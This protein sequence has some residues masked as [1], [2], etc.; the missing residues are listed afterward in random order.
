MKPGRIIALAGLVTMLAGVS[1]LYAQEPGGWSITGSL[2]VA[3]PPGITATLLKNG[4]VL[5]VGGISAELYEPETGQWSPAGNP[6]TPRYDHIAVRLAN[7]NVLVAGGMRIPGDGITY[8]DRFLTGAEIYDPVTGE[9]RPAGNL[10]VHRTGHTAHLLADG[11]V[12]VIGGSTYEISGNFQRYLNHSSA[13]IYDPATNTWSSAGT[14]PS[15]HDGHASTLLANGDVLVVGGRGDRGPSPKAEIFDG[16]THIWRETGA[17]MTGRYDPRAT[18]LPDGKVLVAGGTGGLYG[19]DTAEVYDPAT[20]RW[21]ET[22]RMTARRLNHTATLLP[23]GKVLVAG[24]HADLEFEGSINVNLNEWDTAELYDPVTGRW[25]A[26]ARMHALHYAHTAT[27]LASGRVLVVG[28]YSN[29]YWSSAAEVYDTGLPFLTLNSASFC[30]GTPW[31]L[32]VSSLAPNSSIRLVGTSNGQSWEIRDWQKTDAHGNFTDAGAFA[33]DAEGTHNLYVEV[34]G[35]VSNSVPFRVTRC[36]IQLTLNSNEYCTGAPWNLKITSDFPNAWMNLSGTTN[37]G[38]WE[39]VNWRRTG[40]DGA[41]SEA[42]TFVPG[43]E[44]S[45]TMRV[46]IGAAQSNLFSF[47]VSRCGP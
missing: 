20:G 6:I 5:V 31:N 42:G 14:M 27:L 41:F 16:A 44:G 46:G 43:S 9:W 15:P 2:A 30:S 34:G 1:N 25:T 40:T 38:P 45:H 36:Q 8:N 12:L 17:L 28:G 19:L 26:T 39:L 3:R 24:G 37:N 10:S 21:S 23:G 18:L 29:G 32:H 35:K 22:G 4:K 11:T 33:A 47:R 7:G 13:E